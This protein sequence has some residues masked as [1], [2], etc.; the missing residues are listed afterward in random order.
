MHMSQYNMFATSKPFST[1]CLAHSRF[2]VALSAEIR[3][4]F[5]NDSAGNAMIALASLLP[6]FLSC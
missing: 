1:S 2:C 3:R 5:S 6:P 4:R